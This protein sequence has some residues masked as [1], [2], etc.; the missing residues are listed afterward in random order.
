MRT[1]LR[2]AVS[3]P[4]AHL[5]PWLAPHPHNSQQAARMSSNMY[6]ECLVSV[7]PCTPLG[8]PGSM[9][10]SPLPYL[11]ALPCVPAVPTGSSA[12]GQ[13]HSVLG[14]LLIPMLSL[15]VGACSC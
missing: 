12:L 15:Q 13:S 6:L 7:H 1:L 5:A 4:F 11:P 2:W 8:H 10:P 14:I 9:L 3:V